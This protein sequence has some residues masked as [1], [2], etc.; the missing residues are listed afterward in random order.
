MQNYPDMVGL[1]RIKAQHTV[2]FYSY[3]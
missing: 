1:N 3:S 2:Y